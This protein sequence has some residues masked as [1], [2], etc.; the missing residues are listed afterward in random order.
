MLNALYLLS[1]LREITEDDRMC[2]AENTYGRN[3][4][5]VVLVAGNRIG[6]LQLLDGDGR[7]M[8]QQI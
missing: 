2:W 4:K 7:L 5:Y 8:L 6:N 3:K 1:I